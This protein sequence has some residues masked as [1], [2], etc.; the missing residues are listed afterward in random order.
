MCT[1][2]ILERKNKPIKCICFSLTLPFKTWRTKGSYY[3]Q[4]MI[5]RLTLISI[6]YF[7]T[8]M[9]KIVGQITR[10]LFRWQEIY[11]SITQQHFHVTPLILPRK[12]F[13]QNTIVAYSRLSQ[14]YRFKISLSRM[15]QSYA[16]PALPLPASSWYIIPES[17]C[18]TW[19]GWASLSCL[20]RA[21]LFAS[22]G[23][24]PSIL[25]ITSSHHWCLLR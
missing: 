23:F 3:H 18:W 4:D 13:L 2:L 6:N 25:R 17:K 14:Y 12:S 24:I 15:L 11:F 8:G 19:G 7:E 20:F 22:M 21:C 16:H 10:D 1:L 5:H 9:K